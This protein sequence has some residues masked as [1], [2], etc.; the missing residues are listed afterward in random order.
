[1][2]ILGY[3]GYLPFALELY[4]MYYFFTQTL[5]DEEIKIFKLIKNKSSI[6]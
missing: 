2:P 5:H 6:N 1:M 3:L 4:A